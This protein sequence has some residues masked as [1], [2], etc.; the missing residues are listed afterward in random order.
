MLG[1]A[2]RQVGVMVLH[3][4][5]LDAAARARG[6]ST[7]SRDAGRARP[8]RGRPRRAA[9]NDRCRPRTSAASR[10]SSG[11]RRG[12]RPRRSIPS[13]PRTCSSAPRRRRAGDARRRR[14]AAAP[15]GR[16]RASGAAAAAGPRPRGPRCRRCGSRSA[17][18]G[19]GTGRRSRRAAPV[20]SS[21]SK[22]IGSSETLPLVST[23]VV[24]VSA[25]SRWCSGEYGSITPSSAERG[26]TVGRHGRLG[27]PRRQH[28]RPRAGGE[29]LLLRRAQLDQLAR[30]RDARRHQRE[31]LVLAMLAAAQP[32]D[33][34]ARRRRGRPGGSRRCP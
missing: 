17:G 7:G 32:G 2:R 19:R 23:S 27:A 5:R 21:S 24:P 33:G 25:A 20:A 15:P 26:A 10:S 4:D 18:R 34:V 29:Q 14:A 9:G 6:G 22:A 13:R 3:A 30:D 28:D 31:R 8:P 12:A 16:T 11:R 1:Q